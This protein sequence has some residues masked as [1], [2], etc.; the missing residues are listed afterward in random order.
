LQVLVAPLHGQPEFIEMSLVLVVE[1]ETLIRMSTVEA[2]QSAGFDVLEAATGEQALD[3]LAKGHPIS[4]VLTDIEMPGP[5]DGY[6]LAECI[7]EY[8]PA[9]RVVFMSGRIGGQDRW[10][11]AEDGILYKPVFPEQITETLHG[12][13]TVSAAPH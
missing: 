10:V 3:L 5:V 13:D 4:I 6:E 9:V 1:D 7:H 8:W 12:I 2:V 11:S